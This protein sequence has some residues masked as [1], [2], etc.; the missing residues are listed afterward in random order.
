MSK[1]EANVIQLGYLCA[2]WLTEASVSPMPNSLH[3]EPWGGTLDNKF[4]ELLHAI[5]FVLVG[6]HIVYA[7]GGVLWHVLSA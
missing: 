5:L 7:E 4:V 6:L 1:T 3:T 2:L